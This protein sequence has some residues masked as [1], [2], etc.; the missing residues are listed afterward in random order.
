MLDKLQKRICRTAGATL[1]ASLEPLTHC[2]NVS[3]LS[4]FY[5]YYFGRCSSKPSQLVSLPY[6]RGRYTHY[7]VIL[8]DFLSPFLDVIRISISTLSFLE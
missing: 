4:L 6:S 2:R 7:S 8:H 5:S 3:S 1:G